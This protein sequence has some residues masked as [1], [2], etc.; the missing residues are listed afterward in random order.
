MNTFDENDYKGDFKDVEFETIEIDPD[1]EKKIEEIEHMQKKQRRSRKKTGSPEGNVFFSS[2]WSIAKIAIFIFIVLPVLFSLLGLTLKF[3]F[4]A[5]P[6][7]LIATFIM[8]LF[9]R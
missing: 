2:L 3:L 8:R 5:I 1:V 4:Y 6:V 7:F 9:S